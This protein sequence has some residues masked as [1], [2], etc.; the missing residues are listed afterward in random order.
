MY[1]LLTIAQLSDNQ[2]IYC[3]RKAIHSKT[4]SHTQIKI[5]FLKNY[6]IDAFHH[7]FVNLVFPNYELFTDVNA[8]YLDFTNKLM[9]VIN[10]I[11]P[12]K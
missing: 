4:N 12:I 5:R 10:E 11:A 7:Y 8:A 2:L 6:T 9:S 3:T 1:N